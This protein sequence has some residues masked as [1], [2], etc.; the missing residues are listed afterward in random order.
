MGS[1]HRSLI[2]LIFEV[3]LVFATLCFE[4]PDQLRY[5]AYGVLAIAI[6][7]PTH[8][9]D[10]VEGSDAENRQQLAVMSLQPQGTAAITSAR[11]RQVM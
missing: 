11:F 10:M 1:F 5:F 2:R 3:A 6:R 4:L 7:F 8:L 9:R